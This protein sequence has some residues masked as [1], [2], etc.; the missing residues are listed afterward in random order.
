MVVTA[1]NPNDQIVS[2]NNGG[3]WF[4][5]R[6]DDNLVFDTE[7]DTFVHT[8]CIEKALKENP[9]HPEAT[10]MKYLLEE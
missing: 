6:K 10:L 1:S 8:A 7:W 4:C 9:D 5:Y 3:C 2:P